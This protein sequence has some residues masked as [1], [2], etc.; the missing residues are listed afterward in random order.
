M[1]E[2]WPALKITLALCSPA[3]GAAIGTELYYALNIEFEY[4]AF[5]VFLMCL[6]ISV[7]VLFRIL[8]WRP[9]IKVL[10]IIPFAALSVVA[11]AFISLIVAAANGDGL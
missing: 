7:T 11:A 5:C 6:V 1:K 9:W 8:D 3:L 2:A 4:F 10:A